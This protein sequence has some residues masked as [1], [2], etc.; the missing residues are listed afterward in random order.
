MKT[1]EGDLIE[2]KEGIVFDVKGLVHPP[3]RIVAFPR[4]FPEKK[5]E[6]KRAGTAYGK[7]YS[8]SKRHAFLKERHPHYLVHDSVF[9][10]MLCEVPIEDT[11]M[12]YNPVEKLQQLHASRDLDPVENDALQLAMLLKEN[13]KIPRSAIG[14]SGSVLV[15]LHGAG[16]DIDPIVYGIENCLK[17]H[18]ALKGLLKDV[19]S[20]VRPYNLRE[21]RTLF[22]FRSKDTM[23]SF[24]NFVRTESR[25]VVQGKFLQRDYF[26]RF[27]KDW[28]EV[29][30]KYGDITYKNCG[31]A[32]IEATVADDSESIFTPCVYRIENVK[33]VEGTKV[34]PIEE[35]ASFRGRFCEQAHTGE[36]VVAQG[37]VERVTDA[38]K[39]HEYYRL[40]LGNKPADYMIPKL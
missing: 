29:T 20:H 36:E 39:R 38:R 14:L 40:L 1:R 6:R 30:E 10:E 2:N 7:V 15:G 16:S 21:L 23:V 18:S 5:G 22:D 25:K 9:G 13:A 28:D 37:K 11:K 8:L 27:I 19:N 3:D 24:E 31:Y 12:H 35:I 4:Y 33:L 17:V 32:K 34:S 26:I